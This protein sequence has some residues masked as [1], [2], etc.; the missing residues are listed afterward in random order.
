MPSNEGAS[1]RDNWE[2]PRLLG[3]LALNDAEN[4]EWLVQ[5]L[6]ALLR[7]HDKEVVSV[8]V[9]GD[10]VVAK[11]DKIKKILQLRGY[12][13]SPVGA[14]HRPATEIL[15]LAKRLKED[16][17]S[18]LHSFYGDVDQESG[19]FRAFRSRSGTTEVT[20]ES[21]NDLIV[22]QRALREELIALTRQ[23]EHQL[24]DAQRVMNELRLLMGDALEILAISRLHAHSDFDELVAA[25]G[26]G[27]QVTVALQRYGR[28]RLVPADA[29]PDDEWQWI[30]A[31]NPNNGSVSIRDQ[32]G[33]VYIDGDTG[34]RDVTKIAQEDSPDVTL[35]V[36][37]RVHA[38]VQYAQ[39]GG[40]EDYDQVLFAPDRLQDRIFGAS[41]PVL[42]LPKGIR[43]LEGFRSEETSERMNPP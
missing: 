20:P 24:D 33:N 6:S 25:F 43:E 37:R 15:Q 22:R 42:Q 11:A 14:Q 21:L 4:D 30:A 17:D 2:L 23:I 41:G 13:C 18:A 3:E 27:Q 12:Q 29:E 32:S 8:L 28:W 1:T 39:E 19:S 40:A 36:L 10:S 9:A 26:A 31:I 16:R 7:P 35:A 5:I 38:I 34:W